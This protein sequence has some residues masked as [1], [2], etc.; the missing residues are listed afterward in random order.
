MYRITVLPGDGI[1]QEVTAQALIVLKAVAR[2]FDFDYQ[3]TFAPIGG[4]AIEQMDTPL[5]DATLRD[6]KSA[7]AVL[8]GAV[9]GPAW[10]KLPPDKRPERGILG[11]RSELQ[12]FANLRPIIVYDAL[13]EASPLK[14][15]LLDGGVDILFVRELTGGIYFGPRG[16]DAASAYDTEVYS[17][18]E[19]TRIA[20]VAFQLA[21]KRKGR[22]TSVDK[23][24]VLASSQ[25]WR[26]EVDKQ[27]K[28]F[29]D[30]T[31]THLYVDNAA[32]QLIC[33]PRTFDVILTNNLFGDILSDEASQITGSIGLLPSASIG[34][35]RFGLYEPIHGSSPDIAGKN[36]ANPIASILSLAMMLRYSLNEDNAAT[37][38]EGA[39][40]AV[41]ARGVRTPDIAANVP[42]VSTAQMGQLIASEI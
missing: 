35:G 26:A 5:P 23:A 21:Q 8:L 30:V 10:D 19:I 34:E 39:V 11:L 36:I 31:L 38:I 18:D 32:M 41:L 17:A 33:R 15:A 4:A 12:L 24:N 13:K 3:L 37:A 22:L 1:G 27:S 14:N 2:R 20:R 9:G 29:P 42:A 28:Q 7:N 25:L 16:T 6:C 40:D